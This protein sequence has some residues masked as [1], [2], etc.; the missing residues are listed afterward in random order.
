MKGSYIV[1][2]SVQGLSPEEQA[3]VINEVIKCY[4]DVANAWSSDKNKFE[5]ARLQEYLR[6]LSDK[7]SERQGAL[8]D[9]EAGISKLDDE[10]DR[11]RQRARIKF[12]EA[13]LHDLQE[14]RKG[15]QLRVEQ[16]R[17]D[18]RGEARIR[19]IWPAMHR[20]R[21]SGAERG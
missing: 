14:M 13:D 19:Q 7:I 3:L 16:L 2:V 12:V 15:V 21:T 11:G 4:L 1:R 18:S 6:G 10:S 9:L 8:L 17:F 5:V 20:A